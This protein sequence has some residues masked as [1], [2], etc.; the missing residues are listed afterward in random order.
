MH[1]LFSS[2]PGLPWGEATV[3]TFTAE[4]TASALYEV[5]QMLELTAPRVLQSHRHIANHCIQGAKDTI[6]G[7]NIEL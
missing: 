2:P 5:T 3:S 1:P 6:I 4:V 7:V